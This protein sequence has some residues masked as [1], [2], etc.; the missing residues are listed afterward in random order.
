MPMQVGTQVCTDAADEYG[1]SHDCQRLKHD[2]KH[3]HPPLLRLSVDKTQLSEPLQF[4][5]PQTTATS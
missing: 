2:Q 3:T 4:K 1:S 5:S